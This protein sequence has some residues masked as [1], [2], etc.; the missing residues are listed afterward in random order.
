MAILLLSSLITMANLEMHFPFLCRPLLPS[1]SPDRVP[2]IIYIDSLP[3][4]DLISCLI[5]VLLL[6][7]LL[8]Q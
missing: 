2:H 5:S 3:C 1:S 7:L 8:L 4:H 6:L